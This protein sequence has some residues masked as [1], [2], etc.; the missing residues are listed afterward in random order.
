MIGNF[1]ENFKFTYV[2]FEI[3]T[4]RFVN[5]GLRL[6]GYVRLKIINCTQVNKIRHTVSR[7]TSKKSERGLQ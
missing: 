6:Y 2:G 3:R 5:D 4:E 1:F 7:K